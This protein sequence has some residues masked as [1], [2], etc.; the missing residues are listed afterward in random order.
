MTKCL[1]GVKGYKEVGKHWRNTGEALEKH[2]SPPDATL[3]KKSR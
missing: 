2:S 1:F 3:L